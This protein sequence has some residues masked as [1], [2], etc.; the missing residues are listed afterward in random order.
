M[1]RPKKPTTGQAPISQKAK[2]GGEGAGDERHHDQHEAG[3]AQRAVRRQ[4]PREDRRPSGDRRALPELM[5][6]EY[7]G[8]EARIQSAGPMDA[9]EAG[10]RA[11]PKPFRYG[12]IT[13]VGVL[14]GFSLAFLT[15]WAAN[16]IPWGLS[17]TCGS[18]RL[19]VGVIFELLARWRCCSIRAASSSPRYRRAIRIFLDRPGSGR[20]RR[21]RGARRRHRHRFPQRRLTWHPRQGRRRTRGASRARRRSAASPPDRRSSRR[22]LPPLRR[23]GAEPEGRARLREP[24]HAARRRGAVGAG[25]RRRR[26]QGDA[27]ALHARRHAGED[28]RRSARTRSPTSSAPSASS[29]PR[30]GTSSPCRG[31]SSPSIGGE[32]PRTREAL[33]TLP[34]VGRKTANVVLNIA[35][36]EPTIAVDTHIFRV[37]NRT[38]IAPGARSAGGRSTGSRRVVPD[39]LQAPR[40]PLAD[41]ARPLRLHRRGSPTARTA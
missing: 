36:G 23:P 15:A 4:T 13:V 3:R 17:M 30:R 37:A 14:T 32:V 26:Q 20:D 27:G 7:R 9:S 12:S 5:A 28:G 35:F 11:D 34:G 2:P 39:A 1:S 6:A 38:G 25:D 29:A 41:P 33:E 22:G 10:D 31:S 16:P 40:P 8:G 24:V 21:R 18:C 19:V